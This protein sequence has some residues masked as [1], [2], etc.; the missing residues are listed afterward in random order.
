[1][2]EP[3]VPQFISL[4]KQQKGMVS[5]IR[6]PKNILEEIKQD[7]IEEAKKNRET[8]GIILGAHDDNVVIGLQKYNIGSHYA[9]GTYRHSLKKIEI[10][11]QDLFKML[12]KQ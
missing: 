10:V 5:E 1:M 9:F 11:T 4:S 8:L 2:V 6:I 12:K 3:M 7:A